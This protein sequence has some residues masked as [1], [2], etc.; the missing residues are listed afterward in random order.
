MQVPSERRPRKKE[1]R[2][3]YNLSSF[4]SLAIGGFSYIHYQD[5]RRRYSEYA[6]FDTD[7]FKCYT[8]NA[9]RRNKLVALHVLVDG[10]APVHR[11]FIKISVDCSECFG[12]IHNGLYAKLFVE[13]ENHAEKYF[14]EVQNKNSN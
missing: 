2:V 4:C 9:I 3:A 8:I 12:K 5:I 10:H 14:T 13:I 1:S 7:N 6:F 11:V